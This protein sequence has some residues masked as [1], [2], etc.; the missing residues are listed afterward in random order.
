MLRST[1]PPSLVWRHERF[2]FSSP[3]KIWTTYWRFN[4]LVFYEKPCCCCSLFSKHKHDFFS[5]WF[6]K[7]NT[8]NKKID[9]RSLKALFR[10][11][12]V[13]NFHWT[14]K[15]LRKMKES[16]IVGW[17]KG[18]IAKK[19]PFAWNLYLRY[20]QNLLYNF[21]F[22]GN[23]PVHTSCYLRALLVGVL[24][25]VCYFLGAELF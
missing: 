17:A 25:H 21:D 24:K 5:C 8:S 6:Y 22:L 23:I 15:R 13:Y 9:Q 3:L 2:I 20:P 19:R 16:A 1:P 11:N 4:F 18:A 12:I 14:K 7:G 10:S